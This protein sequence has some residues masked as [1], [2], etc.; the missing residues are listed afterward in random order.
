M[1][2]LVK[3][4]AERGLWL[5]D[6]PEP[7][8]GINDVLVRV[9]YT[10][11]CG[12]DVHI[13]EWDEWA[14]KTIPVPM[15]IGHEFVG[16]VV[17]VGS[18]VNDFFAGDIVERR[19]PR[20]VRALPQLPGRPPAL[21][22]V[23]AGRRRQPA[24]RVCRVYCAAHDQHLAPQ[25]GHQPGGC[26][27]LRPLRQRRPHGAGLSGAGRRRAD[28]RRRPHRH[29]GHSGGAPCRRA[30]RCHYRRESLPA[31]AGPQDGRNPG[32]RPLAESAQGGAEAARHDR[33]VRRG[34]RDVGQSAM[35]CAT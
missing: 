15:A 21:V 33:G 7:E 31:R 8:V 3:S 6:I 24:R 9:H 20:G 25:S 26:G 18:N 34:A 4:R 27:H 23:Y 1:K 11:I 30:P 2:A 29:H 19:G 32:R 5:E 35:P 28:H 10:G 16:E 22:R 14:Q 13:Y 12:T 17:A